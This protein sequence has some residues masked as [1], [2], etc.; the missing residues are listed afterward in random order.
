MKRIAIIQDGF[1]RDAQVFAGNP[2]II[3]S[4][5]SVAFRKCA[6]LKNVL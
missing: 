4:D 1:A 2:V 6:D 5:P 3:D